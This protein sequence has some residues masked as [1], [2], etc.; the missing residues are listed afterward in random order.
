MVF[1]LIATVILWK[2]YDLTP[3]KVAENKAKLAEMGL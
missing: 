3:Q 1:M 2:W